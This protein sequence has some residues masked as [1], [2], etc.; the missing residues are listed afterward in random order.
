MILWAFFGILYLTIMAWQDIKNKMLIDERH[1]YFMTGA[2]AMLLSIYKHDL[3]YILIIMAVVFLTIST[4]KKSKTLAEGDI[5]AVS[6]G[7][8]GFGLIDLRL[9]LWYVLF[10]CLILLF[11]AGLF[12]ILCHCLKWKNLPARFPAVPGILCAF[13]LVVVIWSL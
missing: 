7:I 11:E 13:I 5:Q 12:R 2:T 4:F 9:S 3:L 1:N 8:V 6:W 10:L